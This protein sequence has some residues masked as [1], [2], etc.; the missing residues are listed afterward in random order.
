[1]ENGLTRTG[2]AIQACRLAML[3][4]LFFSG[5]YDAEPYNLLG[6]PAVDIGDRVKFRNRCD[7]LISPEDLA[8]NRY[9]TRSVGQTTGT[10][11]LTAVVRNTGAVA[12]GSFRVSM[13]VSCGSYSTDLTEDCGSIEPGGERVVRFDWE[14]PT[15][16]VP[17][18]V[19][20]LHAV[21]DP[22]GTCLDSWTANNDASVDL[23]VLDF[24]P[25][26]GSWPARTMGSVE[27]PPALGD[28]DGDES[29]EIVIIDGAT[30]ISAYDPGDPAEPIWTNHEAEFILPSSSYDGYTVPL[31]ADVSGSSLPEV[32]CD[33][34]D[35]LVVLD[36]ADG[37]ELC[38]FAHD[39]PGDM[40]C[41]GV[42]TPVVGDLWPGGGNEIALICR[43][44]SGSHSYLAVLRAGQGA[45][46]HLGSWDLP[47][48][49]PFHRA[50][51]CAGQLT[52]DG[53]REIVVSHSRRSGIQRY[54]GIW[55]WDYDEVARQATF[56]G[57]EWLEGSTQAA[58][59]FG[60]PALGNLASQGMRIALSREDSD[61]EEHS[62]LIPA[63]LLDPA[64]LQTPLNC[65][66][67]S[68]PSDNILCCM[69]A[70]WD[71]LTTGLDRVIAPAENQAFVWES[72][73][74]VN[75]YTEFG[76]FGDPRPPFGA[77]GNLDN[78]GAA[79][80]L[81]GTRTGMVQAFG[82]NGV[83]LTPLGF[84]YTLPSEVCGGYCIADIDLDGKVE[85]VFGT[86][87]NYLHVWELGECDEGYTPWPQVQ[88]DAA[89]TG[90]L[91]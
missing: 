10:A 16:L 17:P 75:W 11:G 27:S 84:P 40:W 1:M 64:D 12:S 61:P 28:L 47:S 56:T 31:I 54:M 73:G 67:T 91:E 59:R 26:D 63:W 7:L 85:V 38:S 50:W 8:Q 58:E 9:L 23:Q 60:I 45:M 35:R 69:M 46:T 32:V 57:Q 41:Q 13:T 55:L 42:T 22:Q 83:P 65:Q 24:Y 39:D 82:S 34:Y 68:T 66:P 81:V 72:D 3:D 15:T 51:L 48:S 21:A 5:G 87:D 62:P 80:L 70:D 36:G 4:H 30:R 6:D 78:L 43:D 19:L 44:Y 37:S 18:L 14:V 88:H 52:V 74:R 25:N 49:A 89:R 53:T 76:S 90:V 79:D 33:S 2:D 86:M 71:P 29:L 77:L 20:T